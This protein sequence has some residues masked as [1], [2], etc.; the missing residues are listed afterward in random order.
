MCTMPI[1]MCIKHPIAYIIRA[2]V[3]EDFWHCTLIEFK[4]LFM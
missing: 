1:H 4:L 2:S 3:S